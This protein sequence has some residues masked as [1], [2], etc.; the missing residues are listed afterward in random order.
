[1]G[2]YSSLYSG[3]IETKDQ[4]RTPPAICRSGGMSHERRDYEMPAKRFEI[5]LMPTE[6]EST[7]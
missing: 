5:T 4:F 1:M 7:N 6:I 2:C 3:D